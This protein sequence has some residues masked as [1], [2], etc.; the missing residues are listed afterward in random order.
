MTYHRLMIA[1]ALFL[2]A[3]CLK[4]YLPEQ[5][6]PALAAVRQTIDADAFALPLPEGAIAW[7]DWS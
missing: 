4:I 3:T 1:A 6:A 2:A 5:G 7:L